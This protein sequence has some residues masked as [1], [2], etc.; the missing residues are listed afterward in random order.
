MN[1]SND[2]PANRWRWETLEKL[3]VDGAP[4]LYGILQP[5]P[6]LADGV[7][8]VRPTEIVEDIIDVASI[9]RTSAAIAAKYKRSVLKPDDIILSIVGTI[10]KVALVSP[11]LDGGNITQSSVRIRVRSDVASSRYIAWALR[12][13]VLTRQFDQHRL[14]TAVPRL[15]VAHVRSLRVP[16]PPLNEQQQIVAEVEKQFTRL[17]AGV[18]GLRRVQA[19]LK[20]YRAAVLKAACE[21]KLVLT[22]AEL[23]REEGRTYETGAE[24]LERMLAERRKKW[25]GK[26]KYKEPEKPDTPNLPELPEGWG[27][28]SPEQI[29]SEDRY[30][31]S[32]GPFG[33]NLKV[34]D[35]SSDGVPL[36]FVRNIRSKTFH[37][38]DTVYVSEE[39]ARELVA[40]QISAGDLL[41]TKMGDPPGDACI[42]PYSSP[43]AIITADCIKLRLTSCISV[44]RF[45]VNAINSQVVKSQ[46]LG[47]TKGVAQLKVSLARFGRIALPLPPLAEQQRILAEVEHRLSVVEEL[48]GVVNASLQR[49][50]RLRQ[51]ILQRAFEG[52]LFEIQADS[53]P[54]KSAFDQTPSIEHTSKM[55]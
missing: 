43:D 50:A 9:R 8:Y 15:N 41:V 3:A 32:I 44:P 28:I 55:E 18:A 13:P 23:A 48:E 2:Q 46:I 25:S 40:H 51:S 14:G 11:D 49:A 12:S 38:A 29:S 42:Y 16:I 36:V 7:P 10:G 21:G 34:S 47:I 31:F 54:V 26:G 39:K 20:R 52:K 53:G 17:E 19:N 4:I 45:F 24:L 6:D 22:E 37:G 33:S 30:S 5:G 35:Y 27:W 1:M